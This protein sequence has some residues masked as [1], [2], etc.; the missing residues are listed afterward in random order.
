MLVTDVDL[1]KCAD[2]EARLR[3]LEGYKSHHN[4]EINAW[5]SSQWNR[6]KDVEARIRILEKFQN[7]LLGVALIASLLGSLIGGAIIA[8]AFGI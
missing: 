3:E 1:T 2:H 6:N 7:K 8:Y 5:W 4:G